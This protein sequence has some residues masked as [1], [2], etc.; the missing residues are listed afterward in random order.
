MSMSTF[1]CCTHKAQFTGVEGASGAFT[2]SADPAVTWMSGARAVRVL[3]GHI[4][5]LAAPPRAAAVLFGR[6]ALDCVASYT[7]EVILSLNSKIKYHIASS[8]FGA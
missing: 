4:L 6:C 3:D 1:Y 7:Y 5:V 2:P 8:K